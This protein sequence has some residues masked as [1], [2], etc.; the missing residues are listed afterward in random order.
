MFC[1]STETFENG[2]AS[3]WTSTTEVE[4]TSLGHTPWVW[5]RAED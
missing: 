1:L 4:P 3:A 2:G 5:T